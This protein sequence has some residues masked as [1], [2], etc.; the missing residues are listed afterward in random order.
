MNQVPG[1]SAKTGSFG[2]VWQNPEGAMI[3]AMDR[4]MGNLLGDDVFS[5]P[6]ARAALERRGEA[7]A[8]ERGI[9]PEQAPRTREEFFA[10]PGGRTEY[11]DVALGQI[12]N[13]PGAT[14][15]DARTGAINPRVP[16]HLRER[17]GSRDPEKVY[18]LGGAYQRGLDANA[19]RA[20]NTPG[21]GHNGPPQS[22]FANQWM[23]WDRARNRLDPHLM[24]F[25]GLDRLPRMD[26]P[27]MVGRQNNY[28]DAGYFN[29]RDASSGSDSSLP[30]VRPMRSPGS[31]AYWAAAPVAIGSSG[32]LAV[33]PED[34]ER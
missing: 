33:P 27:L 21:V 1:L 31:A 23:L 2:A 11:V 20:A 10:L 19:L 32:L 4:H 6:Q 30:P 28:R 24:R 14:F 25:P 15:R 8:R 34:E 13:L 29:Y 7:F 18:M 9:P 22:V 12:G 3:S 26:H 5:T 17:V 16:E